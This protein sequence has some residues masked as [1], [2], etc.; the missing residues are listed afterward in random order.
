MKKLRK[1]EKSSKILTAALVAGA[2]LPHP[3]VADDKEIAKITGSFNYIYAKPVNAD[4][5]GGAVY[6]AGKLSSIIGNASLV[7]D[8]NLDYLYLLF[9]KNS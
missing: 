7:R 8:S 3:V 9:K 5:K 4:V 1:S 6:N 2:L